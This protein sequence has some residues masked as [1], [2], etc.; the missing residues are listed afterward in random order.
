MATQIGASIRI[1]RPDANDL[2]DL[3]YTGLR[4]YW[5][6][7]EG[8]A[9]SLVTTLTLVEDTTT[10]EYNR[11]SA[12]AGDWWYYAPYG[13]VPDEGVASE[14]QPV[15][16]ALTTRKAI[17]QGV[18]KRLRMGMVENITTVTDTDTWVVGGLADA[19]APTLRFANWYV[20]H[21]ASGA[22]RRIR[23]GSNA[24][25]PASGTLNFRRAWPGSGITGG[26]EIELWR[27]KG[28][29]NPVE[30]LH[31]AINSAR[32]R[33]WWPETIFITTENDV[34]DYVLPRGLVES[35]HQITAIEWDAGTWPDEPQWQDVHGARAYDELGSVLL[36]LVANGWGTRLSAG[37]RVRVSLN[38]FG[39]RLDDDFDYWQCAAEWAIAECAAEFLRRL[40]PSGSQED[41]R[42]VR[43]ALRLA[44]EDAAHWR[45]LMPRPAVRMEAP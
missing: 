14:P 44:E 35:C 20:H 38:R 17:R 29:E 39:D 2:I 30:I 19:D 13:A 18:L 32:L 27:P 43:D 16:P 15:G 3:G 7:S 36:H 45:L 22:Q 6:S 11:T 24:G 12:A 34:T 23:S 9:Y 5:A 10:Y 37:T 1:D 4:I 31:D 8:G 26:D 41:T 28:D 33:I 25:A 40:G 42:D 21:V